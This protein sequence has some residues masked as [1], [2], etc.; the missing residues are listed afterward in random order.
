MLARRIAPA[1]AGIMLLLALPARA[2]LLICNRMSYVVETAIGPRTRARS[3]P[4]AGSASIPA[5]AVR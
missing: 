3:R 4:A 1:I 5:N 2:D